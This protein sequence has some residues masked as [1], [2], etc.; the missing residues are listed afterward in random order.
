MWRINSLPAYVVGFFFFFFYY[1]KRLHQKEKNMMRNVFQAILAT[2]VLLLIAACGGNGVTNGTANGAANGAPN[3]TAT[4]NV[5][6]NGTGTPNNT[7]DFTRPTHDREGYA[8]TLPDEIN[9]IVTL[10]ASNAE[11][12]IGIGLGHKIVLADAFSYDV[13]GLPEGV[14]AAFGFM[15]LDAEYL[16][17][18]MPDMVLVTGM[19]RGGG[20][21]DPLTVLAALGISVIYIPT[22]ESVA[23]IK[24]DI[25]FIAAV[26]DAVE[27]GEA[28]IH[29]MQAEIEAITAQAALIERSPTVYFEISPAPFMFS[30]GSRTFLS[31]LLEK[32]GVV[33]IFADYDGWLGVQEEV[34]LA[35]NPEIIL[36]ST[37][38]LPDPIGEIMSRPGFDAIY[39]VQ[40]GAVFPI[41]ANASSRPSQHIVYA[42]AQ[43]ARAI[44]PDYF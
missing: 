33:N 44:F 1:I 35:R 9:R 36:T 8:I 26:M 29:T 21:D 41:C 37:D 31:E 12:L 14:V 18:L 2:V 30:F 10:G 7:L 17:A 24:A 13:V 19:A 15:D 34:L 5:P 43:M 4:P 11:I 40:N 20:G 38:F 23:D 32:L 6:T 25:R 39:A 27:A 22:A 16:V 28:V 42:L 3:G